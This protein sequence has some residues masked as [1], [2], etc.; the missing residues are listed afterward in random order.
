MTE[1]TLHS[2][3]IGFGKIAT[4]IMILPIVMA[5]WQRKYLNKA[6]MLF[7][8]YQILALAFNLLEQTFYYFAVKYY[9]IFK[10]YLDYWEIQDTSFLSIL[11]HLNNFAFL[12]WFYFLLFP[13]KY[14]KWIKWIAIILFVAVLVNY[15]FI[16]GYQGYGKF[17]PVATAVFTFGV[18]F[19]YLWYLYRSHL[20]LPLT[21]NPYFWLSFA[22][23][24]PYLIGFFLYLVGD[25]THEENY[26]LFVMMSIAKNFFLIIAQVL[27]AIGF[28]RARYARYIPLPAEQRASSSES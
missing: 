18:A 14:G 11:Y 22:L 23:I 9:E 10:P 6:L 7:L 1:A 4:I 12:G 5:I 8:V 2:F 17:N 28:W 27:M 21:K 26:Q 15:L 24:I 20:I 25:V 13:A 16:E 3:F 19:F